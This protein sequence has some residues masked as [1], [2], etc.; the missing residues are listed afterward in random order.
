MTATLE[1]T[2]I[3]G[4]LRQE[5][6]KVRNLNV[7]FSTGRGRDARLTHVVKDVDLRLAAGECLAIVGESGSGKSV[8]ARTLVGLPGAN[9][10]VQ[11]E[12]LELAGHRIGTLGERQW[13]RLR[14]KD[15]GFVMQ[16]ALVSLDPLRPV[17]KEIEEALRLHGWGTKRSRPARAVELLAS[18][19]V[20]QPELRAGQRPDE[21]SG[22][23]R[24]RALIAS[25]IALDPKILI[26]D[27]PTT[28]LDVTVQAQILELLGR[29]KERG[30]GIVLIS[31]DLSV[32]AAL[33]DHVAVMQGG[34]IVEQG[35]ARQVL[36]HP[37]H[38]YTRALLDAIPSEHT[39]G[40]PLSKDGRAR[41]TATSRRPRTTRPGF[42]PVC[43]PSFST[44][45]DCAPELHQTSTWGLSWSSFLKARSTSSG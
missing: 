32:V 41:I 6:L 10:S 37:Q 24:Q 7:S 17:G 40:T 42:A 38:D 29:M 12:R 31:H 2:A 27:E 11:A 28:A 35:P 3:T 8:T 19:G 39:K 33:A 45:A 1:H 44:C 5:L 9:A 4:T 36:Y 22:G 25:A 23:L 34:A 20:P 18:V 13:R 43:S 14:G 26:A 30:T 15:I 21:L 16:D